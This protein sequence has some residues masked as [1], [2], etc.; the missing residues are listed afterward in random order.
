MDLCVE[1]VKGIPTIAIYYEEY[2]KGD[3]FTSENMRIFG[4]GMDWPQSTLKNFLVAQQRL[5]L[6][7]LR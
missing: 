3:V 2:I 1:G 5:I 7:A 4:Q 6:K